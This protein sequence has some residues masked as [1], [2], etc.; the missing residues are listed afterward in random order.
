[1][2]S[3]ARA[4]LPT[5]Q[6]KHTALA[7]LAV[8]FA[9]GACS[10]HDREPGTVFL[11]RRS[12]W[13][14]SPEVD[15]GNDGSWR[16]R[17]VA[18]LQFNQGAVQTAEVD[19]VGIVQKVIGHVDGEGSRAEFGNVEGSTLPKREKWVG[20]LNCSIKLHHGAG[21]RGTQTTP[22]TKLVQQSRRR[23]VRVPRV[24]V[25]VKRQPIS[26]RT[27]TSIGASTRENTGA[28]RH[29]LLA[30]PQSRPAGKSPTAILGGLV[31]H[32]VISC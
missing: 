18:L 13:A 2:K 19:M 28:K 6:H 29:D 21:T 27:R 14:C 24:Q 12:C 11:G 3:E 26:S 30:L 17:R 5:G 7:G 25:G 9:V 15:P 32:R 23:Q 22:G 31:E 16:K 8:G 20:M 1:V 10:T 4:E